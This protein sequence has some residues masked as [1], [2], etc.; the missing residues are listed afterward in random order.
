MKASDVTITKAWLEERC[1]RDGRHL[2]W[3]LACGNGGPRGHARD[4]DGRE[5][6][7]AVRHA[8]YALWHG[9]HPAPGKTARPSCGIHNCLAKCCLEEVV[10][11]GYHRGQQRS[12]AT[13][14]KM[15]EAARRLWGHPPEIVQ[16]IR[17]AADEP[18][19]QVAARLGVG[20]CTVYDIRSGARHRDYSSPIGGMAAQLTGA[21]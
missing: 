3:K 5:G 12:L 19:K 11:G 2:L 13:R 1:T 14:Q 10:H 20:L 16:A 8:A 7:F 21:R 17:D 9:K 6:Q 4:A 15:A 18:A